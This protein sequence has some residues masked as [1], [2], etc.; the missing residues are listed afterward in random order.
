MSERYGITDVCLILSCSSSKE[1]SC[2]TLNLNITIFHKG[3]LGIYRWYCYK[4][5]G[6]SMAIP[7]LMN[8]ILSKR[9]GGPGIVALNFHPS[10]WETETGGFL[11]SRPASTTKWVPGHPG[12]YRETLSPKTK[13]NKTNKTK[14]NKTKQNKTKQHWVYVL[15]PQNLTP[16]LLLQMFHVC[17][18]TSKEC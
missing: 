8:Q 15:Q 16:I 6:G 9:V 1:I 12:L 17:L 2:G 5:I 3:I 18:L 13:Q 11:S 14:Q 7:P 4:R 10:T